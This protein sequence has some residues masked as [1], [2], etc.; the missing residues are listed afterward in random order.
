VGCSVL[1]EIRMSEG[2][3]AVILFRINVKLLI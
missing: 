3:Q 2:K 1:L